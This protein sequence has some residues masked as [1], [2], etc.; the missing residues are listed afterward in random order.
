MVTVEVAFIEVTLE[1]TP[2]ALVP[3]VHPSLAQILDI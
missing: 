1:A 3:V 2:L